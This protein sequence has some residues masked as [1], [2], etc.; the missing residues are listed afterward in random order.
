MATTPA[1]WSRNI[2][3]T[4]HPV[5][6]DHVKMLCEDNK[7]K[8]KVKEMIEMYKDGPALNRDQTHAIPTF[9]SSLSH[10]TSL[11]TWNSLVI[12]SL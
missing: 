7:I 2:G 10:L 5:T 12:K 4:G 3:L 1:Q 6:L 11:V 8:R 9:F